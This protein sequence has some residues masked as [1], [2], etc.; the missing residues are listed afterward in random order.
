MFYKC[1]SLLSIPDISKWN[2][3]RINN[4]EKLFYRCLKLINLPDIFKWDIDNVKNMNSMF[5]SCSSLT[6]YTLLFWGI[7]SVTYVLCESIN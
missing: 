5:Y 7:V 6:I 4:M 2:I 1:S 3:K